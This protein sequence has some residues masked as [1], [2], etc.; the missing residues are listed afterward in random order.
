MGLPED[1]DNAK[2]SQ[3]CSPQFRTGLLL[4][5]L[6]AALALP[7]AGQTSATRVTAYNSLKEGDT[8]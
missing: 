6:G 4:L 3:T 1:S 5:G 2:H 8:T 7:G